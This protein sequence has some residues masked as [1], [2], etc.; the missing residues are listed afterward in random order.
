[1][2]TLTTLLALQARMAELG[3]FGQALVLVT[4]VALNGVFAFVGIWAAGVRARWAARPA[5]PAR[6]PV[7]PPAATTPMV[8]PGE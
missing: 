6:Q 8:R 5:R 1:V 3:F 2:L 4:V 7:R